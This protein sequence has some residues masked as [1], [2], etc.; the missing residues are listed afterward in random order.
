MF[1]YCHSLTSIDLSNFNSNNITLMEY[2]FCGCS[3]LFN[4]NLSNFNTNNF[5]YM[6][7]MLDKFHT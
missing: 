2:V 4:V 5:I 1:S 7:Y 3:S 6:E